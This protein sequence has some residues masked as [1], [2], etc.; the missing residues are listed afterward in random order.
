MMFKKERLS[1]DEVINLI[2]LYQN[3]RDVRYRNTI[4]EY[5]MKLVYSISKRYK[6]MGIPLEDLVHDGIIGMITAIEKF[7]TSYEV[8]FSTY[9]VQW[10]RQSMLR[11]IADK[12]KLVRLPVHVQE[13]SFRLRKTRAKLMLELGREPSIEE[14]VL[15]TDEPREKIERLWVAITDPLYLDNTIGDDEQSTMYDIIRDTSVESPDEV[16]LTS[17][18][19]KEIIDGFLSLIKDDR[20][21]AI[22]TMRYGLDGNP[23]MTLD[24]VGSE[25]LLTRERIRQIET[26]VLDKIRLNNK[27]KDIAELYGVDKDTIT[28]VIATAKSRNRKRKAVA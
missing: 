28:D 2:T 15:E 10:I 24:E 13:E 18:G 11:S 25:F 22:I 27:F 14:L 12:G 20:D 7:D 26:R 1:N 3:T 19:N 17:L 21:R 4:I 9:A 5:N 16:V 8:Q 23:P 6:G